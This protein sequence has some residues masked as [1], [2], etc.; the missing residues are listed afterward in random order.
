MELEL[1]VMWGS[2]LELMGRVGFFLRPDFLFPRNP[3]DT[4]LSEGLRLLELPYN[5][6][7]FPSEI[8][9]PSNE[10]VDLQTYLNGKLKS[11]VTW[12]IIVNSIRHFSV[13]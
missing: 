6:C 4:G 8:P 7:P 11:I 2:V 10:L 5:F 12:Q 9:A 3:E 1:T 13:K